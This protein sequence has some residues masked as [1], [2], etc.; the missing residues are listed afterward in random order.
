ME[1]FYTTADCFADLCGLEL[2]SPSRRE[3]TENFKVL[4]SK[5]QSIAAGLLL[6]YVFGEN[7]K[8]ITAAKHGKP[9]LPD[10]PEF[11][12][13]HS[14]NLVVLAVSKNAVGIDAE[15]PT[16]YSEAVAKRCFTQ[17]EQLWL[18]EQGENGAFY[19]LWTGKESIMKVTG[20]GLSLAPKSFELLPP[21]DGYHKVLNSEYFLSWQDIEG[22]SVCTACTEKHEKTTPQ[23][24]SREILLK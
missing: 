13:S 1:L 11:N 17:G 10:G 3:K 8:N 14:G 21:E 24:L 16:D 19:R 2:L 15:F 18:K 22:Y 9:F 12:I 23:K 20:L 5:T 4:K 6:R 7:A